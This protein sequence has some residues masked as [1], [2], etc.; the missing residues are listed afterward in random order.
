M[1]KLKRGFIALIIAILLM[2]FSQVFSQTLDNKNQREII[3]KLKSEIK[4]IYPD[5]AKGISIDNAL[6]DLKSQLP[7]AVSVA[8]FSNYITILL[9]K[10]TN[11]K[12]FN[13]YY[14]SEKFIAFNQN[15]S[16]KIR[17]AFETEKN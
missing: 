12:H 7:E 10:I 4:K 8:D 1:K 13:L 14:D 16:A 3:D 9:V 17:Y 15:D 2:T 11:D 5:K 6:T